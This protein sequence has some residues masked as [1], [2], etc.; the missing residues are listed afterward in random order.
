MDYQQILNYVFYG[1]TVEQ[2]L[3][4]VL[5]FLVLV[6]VFTRIASRLIR[7]LEHLFDNQI[8]KILE[9]TQGFFPYLFALYVGLE[10]I[11][12]E[13]SVRS[14]L[15]NV[16]F[17]VLAY[18]VL[19]LLQIV[20]SYVVEKVFVA[21]KDAEVNETMRG[22]TSLILN[23]VLWSVGLLII[24]ANLGI[25]V[26]SLVASLGIGSIAVALA[27]QNILTD[28]FSSFMIYFDKPFEVGDYIVIGEDSGTVK[29]IGLK[30]TRIEALKGN[31]LIIPNSILTSGRIHN[32][33]KMKKRR[34]TFGFG[35]VYATTSVQLKKINQLMEKIFAQEKQ[36]ELFSCTFRE[37]GDFALK[38]EV[39]YYATTPDYKTHLE[40]QQSINLA[41]K[42]ALEKAKI[43][44]A[45]PTQTIHLKKN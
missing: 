32:F 28:L 37:F 44:M 20:L 30:T 6:L 22:V 3:T 43:K 21:K 8:A 12:F 15:D 36:A 26:N 31:E 9:S 19:R 18:Y 27:M 11:N 2:I 24:L 16:F 33:K 4:A 41:L 25:N 38:Y 17:V 10:F 45:Y 39:I 7:R 34:V 1:N 35:V 42:S 14:I 40:V 13:P 29:E 23:I 5:V